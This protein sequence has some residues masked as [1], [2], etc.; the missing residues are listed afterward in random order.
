MAS[1][2]N[3]LSY[4]DPSVYLNPSASSTSQMSANSPA[5]DSPPL[6]R[7]TNFQSFMA[8]AIAAARIQPT[9]G[10]NSGT[11]QTTLVNNMLQQVLGAYLSAGLKSRAG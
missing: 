6:N 5:A 2:V 9:D 7:Q 10:V 11:A 4:S 3:P 8:D 1:S